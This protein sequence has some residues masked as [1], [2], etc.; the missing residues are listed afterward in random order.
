MISLEKQPSARPGLTVDGVS[1]AYD[2]YGSGPP[3][4]CVHG[5]PASSYSWKRVATALSESSRV[6]CIDMM[7]F[8]DSEKPA[9]ESYS[10]HRQSE[11]I[12]GAIEQLGLQGIVLVGHS[13]GGGVCL[14]IMRRLGER[15]DLVRGLALVDPVCYPMR[16]PWFMLALMVPVVPRL[17]MK[18]IP[19]QWGF[20]LLQN[21]MYHP[22]N[23]MSREAMDEYARCLG[24]PGGHA[25]IVRIAKEIVPPDIDE[26]VSSYSR[27]SVPTQIIWGRQDRVLPLALGHRLEGD[28]PTAWLH[29]VDTCGHCPQEERPDEVI[30][31]LG[32]FVDS[33]REQTSGGT[34]V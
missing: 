12:L 30:E 5:F 3:V 15:H 25:A 24:S 10:I 29:E 13:L 33:V 20:A 17:I 31:V 19:E 7:G 4:V 9:G 32:R 18:L 28:I 8:G 11:L 23:G 6:V 2:D 22:I 26:M 21:A 1:L 14:D 27:I 34:V 16:L